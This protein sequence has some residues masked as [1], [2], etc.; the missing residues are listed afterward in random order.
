[1]RDAVW[2]VPL[3][4][5]AVRLTTDPIVAGYYVCAAII[6]GLAG[7]GIAFAMRSLVRIVATLLIWNIAV[8]LQG[9]GWPGPAIITVATLATVVVLA[10]HRPQ[11]VEVPTE[12]PVAAAT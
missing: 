5:C 2:L 6:L 7:L 1:M 10:L 8:G 9:I 4:V 12:Q 3:A 11:G